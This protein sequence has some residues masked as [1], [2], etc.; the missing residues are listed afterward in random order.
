MS[1]P[2][3]EVVLTGVWARKPAKI[4]PPPGYREITKVVPRSAWSGC[5]KCW[6]EG[7]AHNGPEAVFGGPCYIRFPYCDHLEKVG[8][9]LRPDR[10]KKFIGVRKDAQGRWV[11]FGYRKVR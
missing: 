3:V 4:Q 8:F 1:Q 11:W 6:K 2:K 10:R 9:R 5:N 7:L